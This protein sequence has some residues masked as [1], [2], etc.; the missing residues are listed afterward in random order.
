MYIDKFIV[1]IK[2]IH[3]RKSKRIKIDADSP[4]DAHCKALPHCNELTQ[5]IVKITNASSEVVYT[6]NDGFTNV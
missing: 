2:D 3:N 4:E 6:L 1:L 5:D